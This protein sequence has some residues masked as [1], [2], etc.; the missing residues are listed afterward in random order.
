MPTAKSAKRSPSD[1]GVRP[2][3][4]EDGEAKLDSFFAKYTPEIAAQARDSS[5]DERAV[6]NGARTRV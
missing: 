6:S 3:Q 2:A 1:R 4:V 5:G